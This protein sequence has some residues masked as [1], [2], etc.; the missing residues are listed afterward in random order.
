MRAGRRG[1]R[2][3]AKWPLAEGLTQLLGYLAL[4]RPL[5]LMMISLTPLAI[6]LS[7]VLPL[8]GEP[9]LTAQQVFQLGIAIAL[10]AGG[11]NIANDIADR[12]IDELND[13][14][15]PL[16][17]GV[18]VLEAWI[19]WAVVSA[20]AVGLTLKLAIEV[21][22]LA[23][24]ALLPVAI[25][26]LL[27]YAFVLKCQPI[28][29][30]VVVALLCAGVP[31]ILLLVEPDILASLP[32]GLN[33]HAYLAYTLFAFSGTMTR[34]IVKDLEDQS[35]DGLAGC[36]TLAVRWSERSVQRLALAWGFLSL[37]ILAYIATIYY[38]G[39]ELSATFGWI[40]VW[41]FMA[42]G[43]WQLGAARPTLRDG[44]AFVSRQLKWTLALA[45]LMLVI[46]GRQV[47]TG[48]SI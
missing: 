3:D 15:N 31:G 17:S 45:L 38:R 48:G 42:V 16:L 29:G 22:W 9:V 30:N 13:R 12:T 33:A 46:Y 11:G 26:A 37:A 20:A 25:L 24:A 36:K 44:Y 14:S 2:I 21:E 35:G 5:N 19:L 34:E 43:V 27:A 8:I 10:V 47:W 4:L 1:A 6:W 32:R 28:L 41:A 39:Q 23:G 7:L 18:S 40:A